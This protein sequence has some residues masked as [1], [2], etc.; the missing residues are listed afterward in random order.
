[1][2]AD[3]AYGADRLRQAITKAGAVAVIP[4]N[5]SRVLKLPFDTA[6]YKERL[7]AE[8]CFSRLKQFRR[9]A[10]RHEKAA[11]NYLAIVTLDATPFG[12][13]NCSQSLRRSASLH[14]QRL[15]FIKENRPSE[16]VV[17]LTP[18]SGGITIPPANA[19]AT[20]P[21]VVDLDDSLVRSDTLFEAAFLAVSR[22]PLNLFRMLLALRHGKAALKQVVARHG[23]LDPA[24]LPYDEH[25]LTLI[26]EARAEGRKVFLATAAD[27]AV[28]HA[29]A[30]HLGLFDGV[31]CSDG[32]TNLAGPNKARALVEAFGRGGFDYVGNDMVDLA[33][34]REAGGCIAARAPRAVE[35][36]LQKIDAQAVLLPREAV[37]LRDWLKLLRVHQYA[38]NSLILAPLFTAHAFDLGSLGLAVLA[39]IAFSMIASGVYVL[40]DL[41]DLQADRAHRTK[42]FRPFASGRVP[43]K[44]GIFAMPA[45]LLSGLG[46]AA[47]ISTAFLGVLVSYLAATT[48]YT[49]WLK[50][51]LLVDVVTL[52]LLYVVR[53]I[54]GAVAIDV[55]VSHWFLGFALFVFTCL[56]LVKRYVECAAQ[57]GGT[58]HVRNRAYTAEDAQTLLLLAAAA[59][60]NA[61]TV[62]AL[63]VSSDTVRRM[64]GSPELLWLLCPVMTYWIARV[65]LLARRGEVHDDPIVFALKDRG[66]FL[67]LAL[68]AATV[69][70]AI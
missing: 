46:L 38:K 42:R 34:W 53:V 6:L 19:E 14:N 58:G 68:V 17:F 45:L 54:A 51:K 64:Y 47:T 4:N 8:C 15:I 55:P 61:V 60:F 27:T 26:R 32:T 41:M 66:S 63:Y 2:L 62:L 3:A 69:L 1:M 12:S 22:N 31:F 67:T 70:M 28:A 50:R 16:N 35:Q 9:V 7:L 24:L 29:I 21:L 20:R 37:S 13:C 36:A 5:P 30:G 57:E 25:V 43:L 48:L 49:F 44:H 65:V 39:I 18:A 11:R 23:T 33:I 56:A 59:G 40:N 10:S 52:A